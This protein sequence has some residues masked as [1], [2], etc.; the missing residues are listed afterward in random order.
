VQNLGLLLALSSVLAGFSAVY[1][2][3]TSQSENETLVSLISYIC[4]KSHLIIGTIILMSAL[5]YLV[6]FLQSALAFLGMISYAGPVLM[7]LFGGIFY[8]CNIFLVMFFMV[9]IS[10]LPPILLRSA[11]FSDLRKNI[12]PIVKKHWLDVILYLLVSISTFILSV[13][14]IYYIARYALGI[15]QTIQWKIN[16]AYPR[17]IS[18]LALSSFAVDIIRKIT[19]SPDPIGAFMDYGSRIFDYVDIIKAVVSISYALVASVLLSF[20]LAIYFRIS[21]LFY[22]RIDADTE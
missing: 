6:V 4:K 9:L 17:N 8:L 22:K 15:T 19:P 10:I 16:A 3:K 12:L 2:T 14:I 21:S 1:K 13:T 18:S 7:S 5:L 11:S 20:P